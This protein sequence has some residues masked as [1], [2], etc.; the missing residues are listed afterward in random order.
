[1]YFDRLDKTI[2][3]ISTAPGS[4]IGIIRISGNNSISIAK[5]ISNLKKIVPRKVYF[6]NI[7]SSDCNSVMDQVVLLYFKG[8][9]SFTGEDVVEFQLHG[10]GKNSEDILSSIIS[11]GAEPALNGEFSF[12][13]VFNGKMNINEAIGLSS[14]ITATDSIAL[15]FSRKSAFEN[16]FLK[17]L[18][19]IKDE[20]EKIY[21]LSTAILDFPDFITQYLPPETTD[22]LIRST[23]EYLDK[24]IK[25]SNL[26]TQLSSFSIVISGKPNVGKSSLFNLLLN[27]ERSIVSE[28]EGTTRDYISEHLLIDDNIIKIVDTAGIRDG[29]SNIENIGIE[30]SINLM[31]HNDFI[32]M[33]LDGSSPLTEDD[34]K[35]IEIASEKN[36]IVVINKIDKNLAIDKDLFPGAV[37]LSSKTGVGVDDLLKVIKDA[38]FKFMPDINTPVLTNRWQIDTA[39]EFR[40]RLEELHENIK[41]ENIEIISLLIEQCYNYLLLLLGEEDRESVYEKIFS[42]FCIGK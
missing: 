22:K 40:E 4:A 11:K 8:P 32:L 33:I 30:K 19:S 16:S 26:L 12:R 25:N 24:I 14:I 35:L 7:Y 42:S 31:E 9:K 36:H 18:L 3:S 28:I 27:K 38:V 6:A 21:A 34:R 10:S 20:W 2:A 23:A 1:M 37:F 13:S 39:S 41:Y 17:Y 15:E 5:S 29:E